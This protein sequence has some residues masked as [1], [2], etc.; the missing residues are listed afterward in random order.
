MKKK[1]VLLA[2]VLIILAISS[3]MSYKQQTIIPEL[4]SL[5]FN[6]PFEEWLSMLKIPYRD[7]II[8]VE[9]VGYYYFLEFLIR[10][11][12]HFFSFAMIAGILY[13]LLPKTW[14]LK[15]WITIG[16]LF[17]IA[18]GDE[19]H[20]NFTPGRLMA[21]QDVLL[22]TTGAAFMVATITL[23]KRWTKKTT[24]L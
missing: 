8:S 13:W 15:G 4:Q 6:K 12:T 3:S 18:L 16:C 10:K 22:D 21:F 9:T 14:R 17:I 2:G 20:Q 19:I 23:L 1:L 24:E 5:F 7:R 11:A